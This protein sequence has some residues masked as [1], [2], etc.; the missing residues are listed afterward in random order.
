MA[1][2]T[3]VP[4]RVGVLGAAGR[5]GSLTCETIEK[6]ADLVLVA[7]V[8]RGVDA[9]AA[10]VDAGADVVVDFTHPDVV[11]DH[12]EFLVE[13]GVSMV[14]GTSGISAERQQTIS[15]LLQGK[16]GIAVLVVPNFALGAVLAMRFARE[17]APFFQSVEVIE[18]HHAGKV[19]APSGTAAAT[20][21]EIAAARSAAGLG[22]IPDATT[23]DPDG[24]RGAAL[25]GGVHV[26][27]VRLPGL[28]AH[29]EVLLGNEGEL[30]TIKHD[31]LQRSSF[32][33]GV[34]LALRSVRSR[35]G[36]T[37]GLEPL[38]SVTERRR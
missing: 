36:L 2:G 23:T 22:A 31:S 7:A 1:A 20:V 18:L 25:D 11:M 26:H 15:G 32:M 34:L 19:D 35:P 27:S 33:P 8:N 9:L 21:R 5:M 14:V 6:A 13:H 38:L 16:A 24:A 10:L 28:V 30:L 37:V 3:A 17:A 29:Q 4:L 12:I